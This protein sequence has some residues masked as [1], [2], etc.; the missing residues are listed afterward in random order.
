MQL[1][2]TFTPRNHSINSFVAKVTLDTKCPNPIRHK[3]LLMMTPQ[4]TEIN[5]TFAGYLG[6]HENNELPNYYQLPSTL[7]YL[8]EGDILWINPKQG[9]LR[10][11]YRK[12]SRDNALFFTERCNSHCIMCPQPPRD[13][14]DSWLLD[15]LLESIP[16]MDATTPL[17]SITGGEPTL[18]F[19]KLLEV[20]QEAKRYL[21]DTHLHLLTNGRAFYR[22]E[23]AQL[24]AELTHPHL[25][26]GIPLY[27]DIP[28]LHNHTVQAENAFD[29]TLLGLMN[30]ARFGQNIEIRI[31]IHQGTYERLPQLARFIIR[32]L[33]FVRH[34]A[35][36][37]LEP[38]GFAK[39]NIKGLWIDPVDYRSQLT[40]AVY[41]VDQAQIIPSIYNHSL[42]NLPQELW[43]FSR[44]SI[45]DWKNVYLEPCESCSVK[46]DCGVFFV[47]AAS[48]AK[49]IPLN[50]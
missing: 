43:R 38:F 11:I 46:Q 28:S 47:S 49:A 18:L 45:S 3:H 36:M 1:H 33:P 27:S 9:N 40:E 41:T 34:V 19:D 31:V 15:V 23:F 21:P 16:L 22:L 8:A 39:T 48:Y 14:D 2:A 7:D 50:L 13:I 6:F 25:T 42:C 10:V 30:L 4:I 5:N 26:L 35:F 44:Q 20:I 37:G 24:L 17:L 29:Q 32:N 12:A